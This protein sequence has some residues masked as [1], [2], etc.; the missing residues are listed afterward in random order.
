MTVESGVGGGAQPFSCSLPSSPLLR[1]LMELHWTCRRMEQSRGKEK[2]D[3]AQKHH[4]T[5]LSSITASIMEGEV[6]EHSLSP[7]ETGK[8]ILLTVFSSSYQYIRYWEENKLQKSSFFFLTEHRRQDYLDSFFSTKTS[9]S[10]DF[11]LLVFLV[12]FRGVCFR[13]YDTRK[14]S[15]LFERSITM[16]KS[17]MVFWV[18][19]AIPICIYMQFLYAC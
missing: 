10:T 2:A 13:Q 11:F 12:G 3:K 6:P 19:H 4:G 14:I 9:I 18:K 5:T 16:K 17:C 15:M 8:E 1:L 7:E